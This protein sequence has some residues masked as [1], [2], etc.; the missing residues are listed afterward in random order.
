MDPL[1]FISLV[2][3]VM[4]VPQ[5]V[6]QRGSSGLDKGTCCLDKLGTV[7]STLVPLNTSIGSIRSSSLMWSLG[8]AVV[9]PWKVPKVFGSSHAQEALAMRNGLKSRGYKVA[10]NQSSCFIIAQEQ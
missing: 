8:E 10:Q 5:C 1:C 3:A 2:D 6:I 7:H 9:F 4:E